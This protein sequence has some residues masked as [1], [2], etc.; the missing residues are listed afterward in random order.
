[1]K[2]NNLQDYCGQV[3]EDSDDD[4]DSE[5]RRQTV[6]E[7]LRSQIEIYI[8]NTQ[9]QEVFSEKLIVVREG[10]DKSVKL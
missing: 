1:M 4:Y 3:E 6:K 9:G 2:G 7:Y 8:S 5:I 10:E